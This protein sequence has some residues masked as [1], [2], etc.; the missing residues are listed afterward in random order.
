MAVL[1]L[2]AFSVIAL[3]AWAAPSREALDFFEAKVRPVLAKNCYTCHTQTHT[4]GLRVDSR[5]HLLQGGRSG[6]AIVAGKAD[7]SLLIQVVRRTHRVKMPPS[8]KL[9][10]DEIADMARWVNEGALWPETAA[11]K[12][13]AKQYQITPEQRAFWS[14]QPVRPP[15]PPAVRDD[16]WVRTPV[17][18]FILSKLEEQ[19]LKPAAPADR[20]VLIRRASF[21]LLGVPPAPEEV[22]AFVGDN[23]PRA[24]EKVV[25]RLLTSPR[26][27]ERWGRHWLDLARYSDGEHGVTDDTPYPNAWRYRNWVIQ[28]FNDDLPYD[29][30][31]KAQIAA[32]LMPDNQRLLPALGFQALGHSP[33]DRVD[34]T[35]RVM[36]GL[37]VG[38]AQC[39]D[40]KYDPIPTQDYYS[41]LGVFRSSQT[42]EFPLAPKEEVE[43][44]KKK[45]QE[46]EEKESALKDWTGKQI[47]QLVDIFAT[48]TSRYVMA[49]WRVKTGREPDAAAAA[50]TAGLDRETLERWV[51]YLSNPDRDYP[52]LKPWFEALDAK[53]EE[54]EIRKIATELETR[55]LSILTEKKEIEDRNYVKLGG[56]KG[57]KDER[58]RQYANLEFLKPLPY[59][60]WRDM[61]SEPYRRDAFNSEGGVFYYGPKQI[62]R[63]LSGPWKQHLEDRLAEI[64]AL[65]KALPKPYPF[66]HSMTESDK[67]ANL[68]VFVR[69]D[70][71]NLGEEAPRRFLKVLANGE[72]ELFSKGSGRM[73]L[74]NAIA[75]A[76]NPLTARVMAN[77]VW[78]LHFG[79]GIVRSPS[80]FGQLGERPTHP[81]LLDYLA[82]RL[83]SN[84]WSIKKLHREILL[85]STYQLGSTAAGANAEKDPDNRL[86]SRFPVRKRLDIEALRDAILAVSG[87]LDL[88]PGE[89]PKRLDDTNRARTVYGTV[90]RTRQE[91]IQALFDFP[92]PNQTSEQRN[93]TIGPMQRLFFMNNPFIASQSK[94]L[95]ARLKPIAGDEARI[96]RAYEL[97][98]SRPATPEEVRLGVEFL[99][100]GEKAW[101]RYAQ[102]L[103]G[104]AEFSSVQ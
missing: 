20:R 1:R 38:C 40:H 60:F 49:A 48:S 32:D 94:A 37:T 41:L 76:A 75:S 34:V 2:C 31:L 24:F 86:L 8:E 87:N 81:E 103:L 17:D 74:A 50:S 44:Y 15:A 89:D 88:A 90:A 62:D 91:S 56:A 51:K 77:R 19:G 16:A 46:I 99:Q 35:T 96:R 6:P 42:H 12:Q 22:D 83:V 70:Q 64:E 98:Y 29:T 65:K 33:D 80:N 3:C 57:V 11:P 104:S 93:I 10:D 59:Y 25:D 84:G 54:P 102:V 100:S 82:T 27:G 69:G 95:A 13:A 18:R 67:P 55:L 63:W 21:D 7:D 58:T 79:E 39:H 9:K 71:N 14:F 4:A 26:Y 68:R 53:A 73:E 72:P 85:S 45:K 101:P 47:D 23:S 5:E 36:L 43:T 61:A 28:A 30:F 78:L 92:N 97:L 66:L 52:Y